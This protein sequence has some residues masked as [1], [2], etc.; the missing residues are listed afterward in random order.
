MSVIKRFFGHD[1]D[2]DH[3]V[4][5]FGIHHLYYIMVAFFAIFGTLHFAPK[6]A[7]RVNEKK[8][9]YTIALLLISLEI[10]YHVHNWTYPRVSLPLHICSFATIMNI[11]LL[12]TDSKRVFN[13]SF[14][15]GVLG[16]IMALSIPFSY[17]YTYF[18]FRYYHFMIMHF[19]IIAVPL[20]YYKVHNYRVS[21]KILLRTYESIL[22]LA[23]AIYLINSQLKTN[24]WFISSIPPEVEN[25][26]PGWPIYITTFLAL[27]FSTMNLLYYFSHKKFEHCEESK[28]IV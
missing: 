15:F 1:I 11:T 18:N 21:Y 7:A 24:Y 20:Y 19:L 2:W 17:G 22:V 9:K 5:L 8:F 13:Y 27:V 3:A 28:R 4:K 10:M 25:I 14:F 23:I 12:L 26:F 16:G 6:I